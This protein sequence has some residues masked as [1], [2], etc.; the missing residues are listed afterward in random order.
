M[1]T[2]LHKIKFKNKKMKKLDFKINKW[3]KHN[4]NMNI[5]KKKVFI[6]KLRTKIKI[7]ENAI[8]FHTSKL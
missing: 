7:K 1:I 4:K 2:S 3:Q 5:R 8:I 6:N